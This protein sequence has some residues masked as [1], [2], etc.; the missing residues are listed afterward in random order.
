MLKMARI[1]KLWICLDRQ[2]G[3]VYVG[4]RVKD[5]IEQIKARR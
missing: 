3:R 4:R 5:I 1:N 2:T